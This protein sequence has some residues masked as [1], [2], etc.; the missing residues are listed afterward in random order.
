MSQN[1]V[2]TF[3][4]LYA[5]AIA[6]ICA[7]YVAIINSKKNKALKEESKELE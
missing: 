1:I 6:L 7:I 5:A 4:L 2:L 3:A